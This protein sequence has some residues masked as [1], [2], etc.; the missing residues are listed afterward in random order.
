MT[1]SFN[2]VFH[3]L[4]FGVL[5]ASVIA[6][7]V[8]NRKLRAEPDIQRKL[9]LGGL[10][11]TFALFTPFTTVVIL[12]TGI[13]NMVN[14]YGMGGMG[15]IETWLKVKI[16]LFVILAFNGSVIA[17]RFQKKRMMLLKAKADNSA[18]EDYDRQ[19]SSINRIFTFYY[20]IQW[21]LLLAVVF[22]S[23]FGDG[24]HPGTF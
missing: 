10:M 20:Y 5:M 18:P 8:L 2:F 1:G 13:G 12:L 23:V 24:K 19:I 21:T 15:N 17:S 11:K 4:A 6:L 14:R 3:L 22:L 16:V 9:Y 7:D